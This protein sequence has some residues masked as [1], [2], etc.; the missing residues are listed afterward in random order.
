MWNQHAAGLAGIARTT[1]CVEGWHYGSGVTWNSGAPG[2]RCKDSPPRAPSPFHS[3][4]TSPPLCNFVPGTGTRRPL[5]SGAPWT[6]PTVPTSSLRHCIM[7]CNRCS[8]AIILLCGTSWQASK[9]IYNN[10]RNASCKVLLD[11][12]TVERRSIEISTIESRG[13]SVLMVSPRCCFIYVPSHIYL[14][15]RT[16]SVVRLYSLVLYAIICPRL[17]D[18]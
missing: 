11:W 4:L 3:L 9:M 7:G 8:S 16:L 10:R 18:P 13:L 1:N 12:N 2:Q 15:C 17:S 6:L 14:T 5:Y